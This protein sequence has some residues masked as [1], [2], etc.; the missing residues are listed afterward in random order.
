MI[1][2]GFSVFSAIIP[3]G[4]YA[5]VSNMGSVIENQNI[6]KRHYSQ[7]RTSLFRQDDKSSGYNSEF[8]NQF[9]QK[10][11]QSRKKKTSAGNVTR[12]N[13]AAKQGKKLGSTIEIPII[14]IFENIKN[15]K[16]KHGGKSSKG[17]EN[18]RRAEE[19]QRSYKTER[20][21]K[22]KG[23]V[24]NIPIGTIAAAAGTVLI[25]VAALNWD[26]INFGALEKEFAAINPV[27]NETAGE[28]IIQYAATGVT[29]IFGGSLENI[30]NLGMEN[31]SLINISIST[32]AENPHGLLQLFEWQQ[33][34]VQ[35]GDTVSGIAQK[36]GVSIGAIIAS[37]NI[38][39]ARRL[40]EGA[41][42]KIPNIDGIPYQIQRG[43]SLSRIAASHNVPLE[44]ILDVNDIKSDD[45]KQG[46]TIFLPGARMNDI[47][48]RLSL[49]DLF[50]YPL[51]TRSISSYYGMR[52]DPFNGS[53]QFHEGVDFRANTGTPVMASFDGIVSVV[54]ENWLYGR[55]IIISHNNGY[56]TLYGHLNS[57]NVRQGERVTRG[58]K[59]A[60]TGNTGYS[61]GPHLHFGIYDKDNK[62]VNPLELLN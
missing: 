43:D 58:R 61:T 35:R 5:D 30:Q 46:D 25:A 27:E 40:Q 33:Y 44:V 42:I 45:I 34:R 47:D 13:S 15:S 24:F 18:R 62:V 38:S 17:Y 54:S 60:E 1:L 26:G 21:E 31:D 20:Q 32:D 57:F 41:V 2:Y 19:S 48:L 10:S 39:N 22:N 37:N 59:I 11:V 14:S 51:S 9:N 12:K 28:R 50:M 16:T 56:K 23:L 29:G 52:R 55:Y 3:A 8:M 49:G 4:F 36:H 6:S 53:L 7:K